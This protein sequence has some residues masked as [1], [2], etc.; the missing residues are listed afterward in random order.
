MLLK[1]RKGAGFS[2]PLP[3]VEGRKLGPAEKRRE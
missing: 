1:G 2:E 3:Q